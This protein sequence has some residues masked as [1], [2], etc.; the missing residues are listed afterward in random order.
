M[1]RRLNILCGLAMGAMLSGSCT[2][3][4][5][6]YN[7]NPNTSVVAPPE[8]LL[9]SALYSV[10]NNNVSRGVSVNNEL[11]QV[12][13]TVS[14]TV[15]IHRYVI[16]PDDGTSSW[17][18][19]YLQR[20]NFLT[21]YDAAKK[22]NSKAFMG[23]ARILDVW[24]S[25]QLTD[26]FG[27][28]PY[29]DANKGREMELQPKFDNQQLIYTDLFEKLEEANTLL[30][31]SDAVIN[32]DD[33]GLDPLYNGDVARWR[34][35]G[36]SLYLRLLL[37]VSGRPEMNAGEKI[38]DILETSA[39]KYPVIA[40][41]NESAVLRFGS[42][43]PYTSALYDWRD[44]DFATHGFAEYF[45]ENLKLFNDPRLPLWATRWYGEFLGVQ[46]GW[47]SGQIQTRKSYLP[48]SFRNEPLVGNIL[49]YAEV[50]F[51]ASEA[52]LKEY[53][54]P[55][56]AQAAYEAGV[57]AAVTLWTGATFPATYFNNEHVKWDNTASL[58]DKMELLH[59]Q[60]YYALFFNDFQQ[61]H[62]YKRTGHPVLPLGPGVQNG[63]RMPARLLY[64]LAI[65][66]L[67]SN[68]YNQALQEMGPDDVN[69]KV[70]WNQ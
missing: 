66:R 45:L 21:M 46:S 36:N 19:W 28:I 55:S 43:K 34:K 54:T 10:V 13:A 37:R 62:E 57:Q 38:R 25:S 3:D 49:N 44:N 11:M 69:T 4:Y 32:T 23:I 9:A 64:P 68:N 40:N 15:E 41:N 59:K 31:G 30:S 33:K 20:T 39:A 67:N 12:M 51:I 61:W 50:Q 27:S 58:D 17:N 48:L 65:Q 5:R 42:I 35:L 24:V 14:N 8:T 2:K 1:N 63:G 7:T 6:E 22:I 29:T 18:A 53:I 16:R 60:K 47:V 52:A 26:M 70:W 56:K